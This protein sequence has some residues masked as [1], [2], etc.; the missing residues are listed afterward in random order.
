MAAQSR[1]PVNVLVQPLKLSFE[2]MATLFFS[3]RSVSTWNSSSAP[4]RSSSICVHPIPSEDATKWRVGQHYSHTINAGTSGPDA[5]VKTPQTT[6]RDELQGVW[7]R[8]PQWT[9][10]YTSPDKGAF[11]PKDDQRVDALITMDLSVDSPT[12]PPIPTESAPTA[13]TRASTTPGR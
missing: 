3:S 9:L 11:D 10:T 2:A 7:D 6:S 5:K 12:P 1:G 13:P 4:L 8:D